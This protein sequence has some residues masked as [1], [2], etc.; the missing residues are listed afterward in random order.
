MKSES[1]ALVVDR[2]IFNPNN[3]YLKDRCVGFSGMY[4]KVGE[5]N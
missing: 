1:N 2:L 4:S 3:P 5:C